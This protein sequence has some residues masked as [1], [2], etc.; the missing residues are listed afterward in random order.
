MN[1]RPTPTIDAL[2][3]DTVAALV[4]KCSV[5]RGSESMKGW[6]IV[7]EQRTEAGGV[8]C[9]CARDCLSDLSLQSV[10]FHSPSSRCFY[11]FLSRF[12]MFSSVRCLFFNQSF[13][14]SPLSASPPHLAIYVQPLSSADPPP[15]RNSF[16]KSLLGAGRGSYYIQYE[17]LLDWAR[18]ILQ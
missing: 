10:S 2:H 4:L 8:T 15:F 3:D 6:K 16:I 12:C 18:T 14:I 9:Q 1:L 5:D 13:L 7:M 11:S 17:T